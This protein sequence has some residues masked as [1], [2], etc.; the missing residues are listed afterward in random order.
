[1]PAAPP[2]VINIPPPVPSEPV[3]VTA[4]RNCPAGSTCDDTVTE[5]LSLPAGYADGVD[6]ATA[7]ANAVTMAHEE[8]TRMAADYGC[9][10]ASFDLE[11][12]GNAVDDVQGP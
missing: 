8:L 12:F 6:Q 5:T 7:N 4:N 9:T 2:N 11:V 3:T 1:M 10:I